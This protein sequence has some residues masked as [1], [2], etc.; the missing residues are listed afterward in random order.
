LVDAY[1][2]ARERIVA[3]GYAW[4]IDWQDRLRLED[5]TESYFLREAAWVVLSAGMR[6]SVVRL[7]FDRISKAFLLWKSADAIVR[8]SR[9]CIQ[10]AFR[11]FGHIGKLEAIGTIA[12]AVAKRGFGNWKARLTSEGIDELQGLPFIGPITRFHLAKNIG[13]DVVKPD[14][15]LLRM[16]HIA[17]YDG[18]EPMCRAIAGVTQDRLATVDVVFWRYATLDSNYAA[19]FSGSGRQS[20]VLNRDVLN[21]GYLS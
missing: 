10:S 20:S 6:E 12:E 11:T 17:G 3:A 16:A 9:A 5:V 7:C 1:L 8:R 15:H 19:L 4:E 13:L 2:T 14:R 18:P 21:R